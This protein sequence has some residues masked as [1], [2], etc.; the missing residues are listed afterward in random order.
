ME[1]FWPKNK[2]HHWKEIIQVIS[3]PHAKLQQIVLMIDFHEATFFCLGMFQFGGIKSYPKFIS[4][5]QFDRTIKCR[6]NGL[7][8]SSLMKKLNNFWT[9][10]KIHRTNVKKNHFRKITA[11]K[12]RFLI[13]WESV[14][15]FVCSVFLISFVWNASARSSII[16]H[17]RISPNWNTLEQLKF[18][19]RAPNIR[20]RIFFS[21]CFCWFLKV[22]IYFSVTRYSLSFLD[23]YNNQHFFCML[24]NV[25]NM[26]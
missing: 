8:V 3:W 2:N 15:V 11:N 12:V 6:Q 24:N 19:F 22:S 4:H 13:I 14:R 5:T 18:A 25:W 16:R 7:R 17:F 1:F 23:L 21:S 10:A 20:S 9:C 26:E